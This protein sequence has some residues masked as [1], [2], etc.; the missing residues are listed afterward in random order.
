VQEGVSSF[1]EQRVGYAPGARSMTSSIFVRAVASSACGTLAGMRT[2]VPGMAGTVRSPTVS[3]SAPSARR[4]RVARTGLISPPVAAT[5]GTN[6]SARGGQ[7]EGD[8][9]RAVSSTESMLQRCG[10]FS[11]VRNGAPAWSFGIVDDDEGLCV[12]LPAD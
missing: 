9:R 10:Q 7:S 6:S 5:S 2:T 8:Q 1:L 3:A 4:S 11:T 12:S